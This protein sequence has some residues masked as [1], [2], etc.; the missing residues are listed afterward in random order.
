MKRVRLQF[1]SIQQIIGAEAL[2]VILLADEEHRR[3][4]SVV[5]DELASKQ[6][7][8]RLHNKG[9]CKT[10]LPEALVQMFDSKHEIMIYGVHDGQYQVVLADT[11]YNYHARLRMSD[12]IL[13]TLIDPNI[14]LYIEENLMERQSVPYNDQA[15][16]IA[17]PINTMSRS[18][19]AEAM[20]RAIDEENYELASQ[21][22]DEIKSREKKQ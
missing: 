5:C 14:P 12:A 15:H 4:L 9:L 20:Q 2:S 17:I 16:G 7:V 10:M 19:L 21:L 1:E 13:L 3:V 6:I 22:R 11:L 8:M 18:H